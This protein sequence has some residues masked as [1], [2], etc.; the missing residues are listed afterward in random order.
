MNPTGGAKAPSSARLSDYA[1]NAL[2]TI[3]KELNMLAQNVDAPP[4]VSCPHCVWFKPNGNGCVCSQLSGNG[5]G[6]VGSAA[7][8][9]GGHMPPPMVAPSQGQV[10][11]DIKIYISQ[12]IAAGYSEV[13]MRM[14]CWFCHANP[15]FVPLNLT[16]KT[17]VAWIIERKQL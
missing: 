4:T 10:E 12:L 13:R 6:G 11:R 15:R 17:N 3:R 16:C 14:R 8:A 1:T 7:A 9:H 5:G 2:K